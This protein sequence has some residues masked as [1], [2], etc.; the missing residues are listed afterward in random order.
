MKQRELESG[1]PRSP[2]NATPDLAPPAIRRADA[3]GA[4]PR[5]RGNLQLRGPLP[6]PRDRAHL[7]RAQE[8]RGAEVER[9]SHDPA[10]AGASR[11]SGQWP[12]LASSGRTLASFLRS[13]DAAAAATYQELY[14]AARSAPAAANDFDERRFSSSLA[15]AGVDPLT[16]Q[17]LCELARKAAAMQR[18]GLFDQQ[19]LA[20][21]GQRG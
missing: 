2:Q 7:P 10:Q 11:G 3:R 6:T 16:R 17:E 13:M 4:D 9:Q 21:L 8:V 15:A 1:G 14:A 12:P 19:V 20:A 5:G 18:P